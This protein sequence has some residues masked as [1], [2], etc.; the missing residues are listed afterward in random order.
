[1]QIIIEIESDPII[2]FA[3]S[4]LNKYLLLIREKLT[5]N[6]HLNM[7]EDYK[8]CLNS[9]LPKNN[10][11]NQESIKNYNCTIQL[12]SFGI[13]LSENCF[14]LFGKSSRAIL[15]AAYDLLE[16]FGVRWFFP[17]K[18]YEILIDKIKLIKPLNKEIDRI[19]IPGFKKRGLIINGKLSNI[20]KMLDFAAKNKLNSI[21]LRDFKYFYRVQNEALMRGIEV[22]VQ[23]RVLGHNFCSR[24]R[25]IFKNSQ[26]K[27]FNYIENLPFSN[28]N[29]YCWQSDQ[30][31]ERCKCKIDKKK[32]TSDLL[33]QRLNLFINNPKILGKKNLAFFAHLGTWRVPRIHYPHPNIFLELA[34]VHRCFSHSINDQF[35]KIN[36]KVVKPEIEAFLKRFSVET[37]QVLDYWLDASLFGRMEFK[38]FGWAFSFGQGR[39]PHIP[40]ILQK[41]LLYYQGLKIQ[42]I[43][44]FAVGLDEKYLQNFTSP[45]IYL[46]PKLL[47]N[48]HVSIKDLLVDFCVGYYGSDRYQLFFDENELIDPKDITKIQFYGFI[49]LASQR[50]KLLETLL[51]QKIQIKIK[52]R[53]KKLILEQKLKISW[54]NNFFSAKFRGYFNYLWFRFKRMRC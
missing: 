35:C 41:D 53:I 7:F 48:P 30:Y 29:L 10:S 12:D 3:V 31:I 46:Y 13:C 34:P 51:K 50:I 20:R 54:R 47:W 27:M 6:K 32:R 21:A 44:S 49:S 14:I 24:K 9:K 40:R 4:E 33:L 28:K 43:M 25:S 37:T 18:K 22:E 23:K 17:D 45:M 5:D 16:T 2:S 42:K 52:N 1:L 39:I 15:Y 36:K 11:F 19:E 38:N 26:E 8:I